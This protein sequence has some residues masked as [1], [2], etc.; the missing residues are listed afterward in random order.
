MRFEVEGVEPTY[1]GASS[2]TAGALQ[3]GAPR[4]LDDAAAAAK[5]WELVQKDLALVPAVFEPQRFTMLELGR[6]LQVLYIN[7]MRS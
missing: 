6:P 7:C 3:G 4:P 5:E 1:S 2:S